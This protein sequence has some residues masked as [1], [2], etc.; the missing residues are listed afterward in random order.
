MIPHRLREL[1]QESKGLY[2][3][4]SNAPTRVDGVVNTVSAVEARLL[5]RYGVVLEGKEV[6]D[7]GTGPHYLQ[8]TYFS[9]R[10][11]VTG[12]DLNVVPHG[13]RPGQYRDMWRTNGAGRTVKTLVRKA[14]GIDLRHALTVRARIG[15]PPRP[16]RIEQM[17]VGDMRF[18]DSSFDFVFSSSVFQHLPDPGRALDEISRVLRPGGIASVG[19]HLYTSE[20]GS[21]DP[22]LQQSSREAVPLWAHLRADHRDAVRTNAFLNRLR[23]PEWRRIFGAHWPRF[24]MVL[25]QPERETLEPAARALQASGELVEYSLEELVTHD[26]WVDWQKPQPP[27]AGPGLADGL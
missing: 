11:A 12:I 7:V 6:L 3:R 15:R 10:N 16:L 26:F 2:A 22:R 5:E 18:A 20:T 21:L 17:D 9:Q 1:V 19:L 23:L 27:S 4:L 13:F 25:G 24:N 8:L 14:L